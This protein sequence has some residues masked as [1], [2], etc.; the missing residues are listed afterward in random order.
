MLLYLW[1]Y[2]PLVFAQHHKHFAP[3]RSILGENLSELI[4]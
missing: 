3:A 1:V 4:E 2:R